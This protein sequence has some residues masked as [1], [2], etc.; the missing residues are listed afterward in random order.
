MPRCVPPRVQLLWHSLSFLDFLEVFSFTRLGKFSFIIFSNKFSI[1]CSSSSASGTPMIWILEHSKVSQRF[2]C[3]YSFFL[4][5]CFFI[6]F[7]LNV[8]FFLLL[9]TIDLS[10]SFLPFTLGSLYFIFIAFTFSSILQPYSTISVSILL[11]SVL[12]SAS[13]HHLVVFFLEL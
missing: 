1:S 2:L 12:N 6:L 9:Q 10:P 8:H 13:L 3:L 11:N 4:N 7:W 5:S